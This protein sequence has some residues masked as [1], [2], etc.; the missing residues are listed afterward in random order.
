MS[1]GISELVRESNAI[2]NIHREPLPQEVD[3]FIR[4]MSLEE[5]AISD[6]EKF[7]EVYEP[8]GRLRDRR[9]RDVIVG[10]HVPP[11][12]G[13]EIRE[14]LEDLLRGLTRDETPYGDDAYCVHVTYET[15]HPFTDGN[16]RSGRMLW[17]WMM[18][19]R[20]Y[21][22]GFLHRFYYQALS[23]GRGDE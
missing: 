15:L 12:G 1:W 7:I 17:C 14:L 6:L 16:G 13:P 3:E 10:N 22:L 19:D 11:R 8:S 4:F 21:Q 18:G 20:A 23:A 9:G 2:E 5:I